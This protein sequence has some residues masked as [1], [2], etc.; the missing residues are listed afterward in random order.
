[1]LA[2]EP[3][4]LRAARPESKLTADWHLRHLAPAEGSMAALAIASSAAETKT[5]SFIAETE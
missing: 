4:A 1:V 3:P 5:F 2:N